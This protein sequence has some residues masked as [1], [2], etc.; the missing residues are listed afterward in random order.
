M[1]EYTVRWETSVTADSPEE[2]AAL[3][4]AELA[5]GVAVEVVWREGQTLRLETI[6]P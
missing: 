3:G 6:E 5:E 4:Q 1:S 2:A